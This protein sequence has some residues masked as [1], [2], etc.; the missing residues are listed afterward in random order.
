ML[1]LEM[2]QDKMKIED[3]RAPP[4]EVMISHPIDLP[5]LSSPIP[6]MPLWPNQ[7]PTA[8]SQ[9]AAS[10][11]SST[12]RDTG[13]MILSQCLWLMFEIGWIGGGG[14]VYM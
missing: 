8:E 6:S 3:V 10:A 13:A 9:Q 1:R 7:S 11:D 14:R 4:L 5:G 12:G 2:I